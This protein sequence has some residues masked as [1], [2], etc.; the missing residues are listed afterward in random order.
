MNDDESRHILL[1]PA[2]LERGIA[3]GAGRA[4]RGRVYG[5]TTKYEQPKERQV[6]DDVQGVLAEMAYAKAIGAPYAP[7]ANLDAATGDVRGAHIRST[8]YPDGHLLLHEDDNPD[9]PFVL[10]VG[11]D[12][13]WQIAGWLYARE[14]QHT[15]YWNP[16]VR[17]PC[18]YVPQAALHPWRLRRKAHT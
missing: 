11:E 4:A 6:H 14:G 18:Y 12:Q 8:Q 16:T 15:R 2:E 7:D 5:R 13:R 9:A 1:T 3:L 10:L 17:Y